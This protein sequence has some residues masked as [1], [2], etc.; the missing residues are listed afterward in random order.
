MSFTYFSWEMNLLLE[1]QKMHCDALNYIFSFLSAIT[2]H[3]ELWIGLCIVLL[4]FKKTRKIGITM[5]FALLMEVILADLILKPLQIR[6]RPCFY[7]EIVA[8]Y[9]VEKVNLMG[10]VKYWLPKELPR[11]FPSGHAGASFAASV[12]VFLYHKKG[13]IISILVA[14]AICFSRMYLFLHFPLDVL[15]G[16]VFGILMAFLSY[17]LVNKAGT[18][19]NKEKCTLG[20]F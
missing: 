16:I 10:M 19:R 11:S 14:I 20:I 9:E 1:L 12:S 8:R 2:A 6:N 13:G 15:T 3:G 5:F 17:Y 7:E 4:C 18:K